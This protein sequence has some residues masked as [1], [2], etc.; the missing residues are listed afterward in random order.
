M[1]YKRATKQ[2]VVEWVA[3]HPSLSNLPSA[4]AKASEL[5]SESILSSRALRLPS[6]LLDSHPFEGSGE[7]KK[8]KALDQISIEADLGKFAAM[9]GVSEIRVNS[10]N[11]LDPESGRLYLTDRGA[12]AAAVWAR[13]MRS[14]RIRKETLAAAATLSPLPSGTSAK[15]AAAALLFLH[16]CA[17]G[18]ESA[19]S[20]LA[21]SPDAGGWLYRAGNPRFLNNVRD[22][23]PPVQ[24]AFVKCLLEH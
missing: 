8:S 15:E 10:Q 12:V 20:D 4:L 22:A 3:N 13:F 2:T 1:A 7:L 18:V 14:S 9:L 21:V 11:C 19:L 5:H 16:L 6:A 24:L 23:V 17:N